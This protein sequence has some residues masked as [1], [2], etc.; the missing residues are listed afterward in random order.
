M[1]IVTGKPRSGT[2]MMMYC[3]SLCG[4]PMSFTEPKNLPRETIEKVKLAF[5]NPYGYFEGEW[6]G[7]DGAIK[8]LSHYQ[9]DQFPNPKLIIMERDADKIIASFKAIRDKLDLPQWV[10]DKSPF[11][12]KTFFEDQK[13]KRYAEYDK[14]PNVRVHYDTFVN[15]PETY[16]VDFNRVFP[17]LDFDTLIKGIDKTL[18]IKR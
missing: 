3:L 8:Y 2:S 4:V 12:D 18:Y 15:S 16:R 5:K 1:Y 9:L 10:K 14:Y 11:F 13:E 7:K 6:N 17:E